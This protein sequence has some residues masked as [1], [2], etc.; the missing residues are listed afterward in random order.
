MEGNT[1]RKKKGK[2]EGTNER[3]EA[4]KAD[5]QIHML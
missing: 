4:R 1:A 2:K 3:R 5:T